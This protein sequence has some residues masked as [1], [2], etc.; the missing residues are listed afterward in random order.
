MK[1]IKL[2]EIKLEEALNATNMNDFE[3]SI[4]F[5]G[6]ELPPELNLDADSDYYAYSKST[7]LGFNS[8]VVDIDSKPLYFIEQDM[9]CNILSISKFA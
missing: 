7:D 1:E 9:D 4:L 2:N 3:E 6:H 5:Y 8:V